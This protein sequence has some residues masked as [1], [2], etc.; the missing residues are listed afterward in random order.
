MTEDTLGNEYD[1]VATWNHSDKI[2]LKG[3]YAMFKPEK[4]NLKVTNPGDMET[5]L[6]GA[7]VIKF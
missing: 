1:I 6:G 7:F 3:Y 5:M 4:K 2:S